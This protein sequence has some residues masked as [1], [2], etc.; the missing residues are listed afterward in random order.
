MSFILP[1]P[2]WARV[3]AGSDTPIMKDLKSVVYTWGASL[4]AAS[5]KLGG[6]EATPLLK[7][8]AVAGEQT[9]TFVLQPNQQFSTDKA[10]FRE[11]IV[12]YI[13]K[14][15][16][17]STGR[18]VVVGSSTMLSDQ[19]LNGKPENVAFG[20]NAIDWLAENEDLISIRSKISANR[21]L[22]FSSPEEQNLIKYGIMLGLPLLVILFGAVRLFLRKQRSRTAFGA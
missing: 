13:V 7:T 15:L 2:F 12:A 5:N 6:A 11:R 14:G 21:T 22:D 19:I 1:Y 17:G 9:G 4:E 8:T 18:A 10:S 20:Q 16:G 3:G